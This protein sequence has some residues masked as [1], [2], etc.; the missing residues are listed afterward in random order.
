VLQPTT[1]YV[2]IGDVDLA[3]KREDALARTN[4][5]GVYAALPGN[6]TVNENLRFFGFCMAS[7]P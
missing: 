1:G 6:L 2:Y 5:A 4:F 3:K 7:A